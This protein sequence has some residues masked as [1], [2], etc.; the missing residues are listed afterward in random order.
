MNWWTHCL[1]AGIVAALVAPVSATFHFIQVEQVIGGVDG[2]T[3]AQAIQIRF[4]TGGQHLQAGGRMRAWDAA[5]QNP[6]IIVDP[7]TNLAGPS[8]TGD[9]V[10]FASA[11][12]ANYLD[13]AISVDYTFTNLIPASYL[14]AGSLTFETNNGAIIYWRLSW[15]GA[16]YTGS[17][18]GSVTNDADGNFGPPFAGP[19]PSTGVQ[20]V[21]FQGAA[22]AL[23]IS[24]ATDYALTPTAATFT[25]YAD[26]SATVVVPTVTGACCAGDESC[27]ADVTED[28]CVGGGG[29]YQGD[30]TAC[31][32]VDC[33]ILTGA[34][35]AGDGNCIDD[36]TQDTCE[37][38]GGVY[39]GGGTACD[40]VKCTQLT[41]ACCMPDGSCQD[42]TVEADCIA[43][44][45]V[46]QGHK[47]VCGIVKCPQPRECLAD[48]VDNTTFQPPPDGQVDAADLAFLLGEWGRNAGSPADMV[49]SDTFQPPPDD[50]VNAADLAFLLG[51]WG[52]CR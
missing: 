12:F 52:P 37:G 32:T 36:V 45:G 48:F 9:R 39:Q 22:N 10:L 24:N 6:I 47:V 20:A 29:T 44:G 30:G 26:Q 7:A 2:D 41:G 17:N 14:A 33:T 25:N 1:A 28:T 27:I 13:S 15:G 31:E 3:T 11:N 50:F 35:C 42:D 21:L 46:Y 23:S 8:Q 43:A 19:L 51:S 5:G 4:R 49:D 18:T 34:C 38:G 40:T 16:S